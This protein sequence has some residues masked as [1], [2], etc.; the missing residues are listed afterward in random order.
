MSRLLF[1]NAFASFVDQGYLTRTDGKLALS[2]SYT[3]AETVRTIEARVVA[4]F[5]RAKGDGA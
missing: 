4:L 2:A 3:S 1:D 5:A